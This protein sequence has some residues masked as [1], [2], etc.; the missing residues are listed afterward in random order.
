MITSDEFVMKTSE[1]KQ[2]LIDQALKLFSHTSIEALRTDESFRAVPV[3]LTPFT[4]YNNPNI[5]IE[6]YFREIRD[7]LLVR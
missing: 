3:F 1:R 4:V 2:V 6:N 7:S 5:P